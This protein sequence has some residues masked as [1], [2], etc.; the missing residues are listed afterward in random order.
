MTKTYTMTEEAL[1][2]LVTTDAFRALTHDQASN[3]E[4]WLQTSFGGMNQLDFSILKLRLKGCIRQIIG[5]FP[6]EELSLQAEILKA[7]G[8]RKWKYLSM[9]L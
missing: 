2:V 1:K 5:N 8:V 9:N 7:L 6:E 3:I 4:E